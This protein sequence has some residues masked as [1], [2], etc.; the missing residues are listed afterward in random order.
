MIAVAAAPQPTRPLPRVIEVIAAARARIPRHRGPAESAR[1]D[2]WQRQPARDQA[3]SDPEH[4]DRMRRRQTADR[5]RRCRE[6]AHELGSG[7]AAA[8]VLAAAELLPRVPGVEDQ[9][10][11]PDEEHDEPLDDEGQVA[12][13][14]RLEDLRVEVAL[15]SAREQGAEEEGCEAVPTA[16]FRPS[17]ATAMPRNPMVDREIVLAAT[18]YSQPRTSIEP[19]MP[20]KAPEIAMARK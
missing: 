11:G 2:R 18:R 10:I 4:A 15:R 14:L 12:R 3:E 17:S 9:E 5:A 1:V 20:A 13:E 8:V 16:V 6:R 19:P 7:W